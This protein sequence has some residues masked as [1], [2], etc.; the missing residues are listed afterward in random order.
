MLKPLQPTKVDIPMNR[1]GTERPQATCTLDV[2]SQKL[3]L[4]HVKLI[5][6]TY[7]RSRERHEGKVTSS[8]RSSTPNDTRVNQAK[9]EQEAMATATA[10]ERKITPAIRFS[11]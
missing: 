4:A 3:V 6:S 5:T 10:T 7:G 8:N 9:S 11:G 2:W 1:R